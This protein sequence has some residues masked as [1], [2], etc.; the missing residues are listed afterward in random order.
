MSTGQG[1]AVVL[2]LF[3]AVMLYRKTERDRAIAQAHADKVNNANQMVG[4]AK[5][6]ISYIWGA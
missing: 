3:V 1:F 6:V 2:V 4:V 5:T